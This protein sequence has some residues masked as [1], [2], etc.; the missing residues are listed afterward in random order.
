MRLGDLPSGSL[1]EHAVSPV[2]Y[3]KTTLERGDGYVGVVGLKHGT[4][5][6]WHETQEVE[7]YGLV[8]QE[9]ALRP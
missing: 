1:F 5:S 8:P 4:F 2:V 7:W 3:I 6:W 9:W